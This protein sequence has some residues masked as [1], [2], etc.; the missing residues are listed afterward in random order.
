MSTQ[1]PSVCGRRPSVILFALGTG[2][3]KNM[4]DI[5]RSDLKNIPGIYFRH[6]SRTNVH[7][8]YVFHFFRCMHIRDV[9]FLIFMISFGVVL[10]SEVFE[11]FPLAEL[12]TI[13]GYPKTTEIQS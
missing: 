7:R 4:G 6:F 5:F 8:V 2:H 1:L 13:T 12:E 10:S 9:V 11:V 3:T